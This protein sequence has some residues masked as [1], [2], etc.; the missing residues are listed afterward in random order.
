MKLLVPLVLT[1]A[2]A[3]SASAAPGQYAIDPDHTHPSFEVDHMGGRSVWR[4]LFK[5]TTGHITLDRAAGTGTVQVA[6]DVASIDFAHDELAAHVSGPDMLDVAKYPTASY[7]GTLGA[8]RNGAPT[9]VRGELT[10]HGITKP[11][12][13]RIVSFKC[14]PHPQ[15]KREVCGADA[16]GTFNRSNFGVSYGQDYGFKQD[17]ALR[18]QVEAIKTD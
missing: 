8:F 10:L 3:A 15:L 11:V 1:L 18:I 12:A 4:G 7:K 2:T 14:E 17:V 5:T 9:T 16:V 6:I 13:L